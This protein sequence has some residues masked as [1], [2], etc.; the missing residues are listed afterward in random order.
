MEQKDPK[1]KKNKKAIA[2][3]ILIL[4]VALIAGGMWYHK[5]M[6]YVT[7]DDALIDGDFVALAPKMMGRIAMIKIEEGDSVKTNQLL[8]ELDSTDLCAQKKQAQAQINQAIANL[9]QARSKYN[10]D[11]VNLTVFQINA[12]KSAN[13]LNRANH[14]KE[15]DIITE[16]VFENFKKAQ[17]TC[18]AQLETAKAQLKVS[19]AQ[20]NTALSAIENAKALEQVLE[21]QL[22]NTRLYSPFDGIVARRWLLPGDMA[23]TGQS[24]LTINNSKNIWVSVY[25]EETKLKYLHIGQ[26][27]EFT[28]DAITDVVFT[29]KIFYIG[30]NTAS[31]FALIPPSNA[32]GN[33]TKITQRVQLKVSIDGAENANINDFQL[34]PGMSVVM[35]LIK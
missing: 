25:I 26:K 20:V 14:Q 15:A 3:L 17:Q 23:Q 27:A 8:V 24:V 6:M 32:S 4:I 1:K 11:E 35:K 22:K 12:D 10:A 21:S 5:F 34:F 2:T 29:G 28:A 30:N 16:E 9:E 19:Q 31:K 7:T 18:Q 13:D 33:F